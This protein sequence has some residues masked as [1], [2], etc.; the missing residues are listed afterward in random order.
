[1]WYEYIFFESELWSSQDR[2]YL[3][4]MWWF[5]EA[6][7]YKDDDGDWRVEGE[8]EAGWISGIEEDKRNSK[9]FFEVES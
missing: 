8:G 5:R 1:M 9:L 2:A 3:W 6:K 7:E 4:E